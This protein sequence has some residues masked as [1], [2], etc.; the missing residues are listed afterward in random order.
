[1][2]AVYLVCDRPYDPSDPKTLQFGLGNFVA[3]I[4]P[5]A[6]NQ[7]GDSMFKERGSGKIMCWHGQWTRRD[8]SNHSGCF[9]WKNGSLATFNPEEP[10]QPGNGVS[11]FRFSRIGNA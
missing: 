5:V 7:A 9:F 6:G 2:A 8:D 1:M 11:E 4:V 3:E 10:G